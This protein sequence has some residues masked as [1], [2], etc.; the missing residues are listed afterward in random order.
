MTTGV[1][2]ISNDLWQ[3]KDWRVL[4]TTC[5]ISAQIADKLNEK[6]ETLKELDS[7]MVDTFT[8]FVQEMMQKEGEKDA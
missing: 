4:I 8:K 2:N 6:P 3:A 7:R 5:I 1:E